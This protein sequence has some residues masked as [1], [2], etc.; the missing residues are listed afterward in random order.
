MRM[1]EIN[2]SAQL[3]DRGRSDHDMIILLQSTHVPVSPDSAEP[4]GIREL[5]SA[6]EGR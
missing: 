5:V 6:S 3:R 4:I 2:F 1:L